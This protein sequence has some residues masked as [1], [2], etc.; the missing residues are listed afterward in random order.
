MRDA[1]EAWQQ[2]CKADDEGTALLERLMAGAAG[3]PP[4]TVPISFP[5]GGSVA[6]RKAANA[7]IIEASTRHIGMIAGAA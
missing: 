2:R 5:R 3:A 6:T 4:R 7:C 1:R